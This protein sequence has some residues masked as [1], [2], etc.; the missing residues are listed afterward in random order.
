MKNTLLLVAIVALLGCKE[1]PVK[2]I[3]YDCVQTITTFEGLK[4]T[5]AKK[6]QKICGFTAKNF[7]EKN[8][9]F[10]NDFGFMKEFSIGKCTENK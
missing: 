1:E 5:E 4:Q 10:S 2:E 3:C 8:F 9:T 6:T 7:Y